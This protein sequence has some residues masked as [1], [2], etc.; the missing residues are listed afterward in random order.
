MT[1]QSLSKLV[2]SLSG[3]EKRHF[4]MKAQV[5]SGGK[6]YLDLF[7][8]MEST[9]ATE[10]EKARESFEKSHPGASLNNTAR[11]LMRLL[12]D[13]LIDL[14]S[15]K[16]NFFHLLKEVKRVKILQERSLTE[17][18]YRLLIKVREG[19][20]ESQQHLIQYLTYREELN[21]L[22]DSGFSI[23]DDKA[24]VATQMQAKEILRLLDNIH[25]HHSLYELL[26]Y[27]LVRTGK[28]ASEEEKRRMDDLVLTEMVL[29]GGKSRNSFS[30]RKLHLLF[31]SHFLT[32]VGDYNSALRTFDALN[33]LFEENPDLLDKPPLDYLSALDGILDSLHTLH[34][35]DDI[36]RYIERLALLDRPDYPESFRYRVRKTS[37]VYRF[38][39]LTGSG[40]YPEAV[41][42]MKSIDEG[43]VEMYPMLDEE[44]QW[45]L[46]F[47]MTLSRYGNKE[48]KKAH[49]VVRNAMQRLRLIPHLPVCKAVRLL[50]IILH[51]EQGDQEFLVYETRS[52]KRFFN[53]QTLLGTEKL[54][55]RHVSAWPDHRRRSVPQAQRERTLRELESIRS[56]RYEKQILKYFDFAGWVQRRLG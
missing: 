44:K 33:K 45:E 16:D 17:E 6:D 36:D 31:Q 35:Y 14:K 30:T 26:R 10:L 21:Y 41:D 38:A 56:D 53:R 37:A 29:V 18:G 13:D 12:T 43:T 15:E 40:R 19:A 46:W 2:K 9:P 32:N 22:S 27:R 51:Y 42:Y 28:V 49:A 54:L 55:L 3:P 1:L 11:Y 4:K 8:L 34:R 25:D 47:Y 23:L 39:I 48:P 7:D 50:N 24:L 5:Q 20:R 52:Y